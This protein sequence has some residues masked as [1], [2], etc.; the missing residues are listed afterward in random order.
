MKI[1]LSLAFMMTTILSAHNALAE[2]NICHRKA[3]IM[4]GLVDHYWISTDTVTAGMGS[5][6]GADIQ[7]GNKFEPPFIKVFVVD[8]STQM[9][10]KCQVNDDVDEKC[11]DEELQVGKYLGRFSP[12]N[13][14]QSYVAHVLHKCTRPEVRQA[15]QD[16]YDIM[17]LQAKAQ[18]GNLTSVEEET[19]GTLLKRN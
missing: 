11:V 5:K 2:V 19:L 4:L 17:R 15:R 14:C 1:F 7:I 12:I 3:K 8:Q 10:D 13:N 16:K 6:Y 9:A 18:E